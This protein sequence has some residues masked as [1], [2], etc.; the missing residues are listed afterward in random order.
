M[1]R[2]LSNLIENTLTYAGEAS[3]RLSMLNSMVRIDIIDNGPGIDESLLERAC[4]PFVR[5]HGTQL[6]TTEYGAG[7]G[8]GLSI[9]RACV[10]AHGGELLLKNRSPAGLSVTI[11]LPSGVRN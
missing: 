9:A 6:S 10:H 2:A 8:L 4:E 11:L 1:K 5:L 3:I 7:L